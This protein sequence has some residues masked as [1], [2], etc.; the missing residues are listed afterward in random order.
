[1]QGSPKNSKKTEAKIPPVKKNV[2][3]RKRSKK[4]KLLRGLLIAFS[5]LVILALLVWG[6]YHAILDYYLNKINI[7]TQETGLHFETAPL[8]EEITGEQQTG[9]EPFTEEIVITDETAS[10][11]LIANNKDVTNILLL[12]TDTRLD[13]QAGRSDVMMM[14]SVNEK[15]GKI[16]L[17]SFL[18]DLYAKFPETPKNPIYSG[19]G[20]D[21]LTHAH[22]YGGPELTMAVLKETFN[23]EVE[24]YAKV[25]FYS[26]AHA[27]DALGG[28]D[29]YL[30]EAEVNYINNYMINQ[31]VEPNVKENLGITGSVS[32][33]TAKDGM[34][35]LN[36][37]MAL[38]HARNRSSA[39]SDFDRTQR[40]RNIITAMLKKASS[41]SLSQMNSALN[42]VLPMITTNMPKSM[43]RDLVNNALSYVKYD[44]ESTRIPLNG[45]YTSQSYNLVP[46]LDVNC[47]HLY[48]LIYGEE[49]PTQKK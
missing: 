9:E 4:E 45:T 31:Q 39:G 49:P 12:A 17:C 25:N 30:T 1:M 35:H 42:T 19:K 5:V 43:L 11:P 34:Y 21:K 24:H 15:T 23:V 22:A 8:T 47:N 46:D 13:N 44:V 33:G 10:L 2:K 41:L 37:A 26:F 40:Q 48:R 3:K 16:V 18:R 27:I 6:I 7:V 20:Y 38:T 14:V 32:L 29:L 36:G 28:V